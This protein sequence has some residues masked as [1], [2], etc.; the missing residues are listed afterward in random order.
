[1]DVDKE[2]NKTEPMETPKELESAPLA[3]ENSEFLNSPDGRM[4]RIIA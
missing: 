2:V 1:M 4:L 3:Y